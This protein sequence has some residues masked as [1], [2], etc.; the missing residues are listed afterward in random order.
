MEDKRKKEKA[1]SRLTEAERR[2]KHEEEKYELEK[3]M[4]KEQVLREK[5]DYL[6]VKIGEL[7]T[8]LSH[9]G[10]KSVN[11][12]PL[13]DII[14]QM[15]DVE[16]T[17]HEVKEI[18]DEINERKKGEA[19]K[20]ANKLLTEADYTERAKRIF[21]KDMLKEDLMRRNETEIKDL[22]EYLETKHANDVK[23]KHLL[24]DSTKSRDIYLNQEMKKRE[25]QLEEQTKDFMKQQT[26][27]IK[28][29]LIDRAKRKFRQ[30]ENKRIM[31]ENAERHAK[32]I[33]E[34]R[35]K[36][37]GVGDDEDRGGF[38]RAGFGTEKQP[39]YESA[40]FGGGERK[41]YEFKGKG[42]GQRDEDTGGFS[43]IGFGKGEIER[44]SEEE[45]K[46]KASGPPQFGRGKPRFDTKK[47]SDGTWKKDGPKAPSDKKPDTGFKKT[48]KAKKTAKKEGDEGVGRFS[49][50]W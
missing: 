33:A 30:E 50:A 38:S 10:V 28:K 39:T 22:K 34:A 9:E 43:R 25:E 20:Y 13:K 17:Y 19:G 40:K 36:D 37:G 31:K 21:E 18:V 12:K 6:K 41:N 29:L 45:T 1:E 24:I 14:P 42:R 27:N 11:S 16:K 44:A 47:P 46:E 49:N 4:L 5:S 26:E 15:D 48:A 2:A 35:E 8:F 7:I 3:K 23:L 32:R